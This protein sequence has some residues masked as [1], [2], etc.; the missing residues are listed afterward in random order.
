MSRPR[1][2][3]RGSWCSPAR[4]IPV[5]PISIAYTRLDGF[6]LGRLLRPIYTWYGDM[7]FAPHF[8][9]L[10]GYGRFQVEITIHD[11]IRLENFESRKALARYCEQ[12]VTRGF[13]R[14]LAGRSAITVKTKKI[15]IPQD[16]SLIIMSEAFSPII[17]VGALVLPPI[18]V[19]IID[20]STTLNPSMPCTLRE[21]S[22]TAISSLPILQVPTG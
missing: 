18:K 17:M 22:T 5:Q 8:W 9:H 1:R 3:G 15:F 4:P 13:S 16:Q 11:P 7:P 12:K 6:P 19:G 21:L 10:L 14:S 2:T 20:A